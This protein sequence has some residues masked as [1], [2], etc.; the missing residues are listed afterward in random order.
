[1]IGAKS[2]ADRQT[3]KLLSDTS[4][5]QLVPVDHPLRPIRDL[6]NAALDRLSRDFARLYV[7]T[8]A[9]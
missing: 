8:G 4:P 3:N 7:K 6:V 5:E 9:A 1:M 2:G